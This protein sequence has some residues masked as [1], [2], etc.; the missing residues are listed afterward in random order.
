MITIMKK[1]KRTDS[2]GVNKVSRK[3]LSQNK[4]NST[5][6]F[7]NKPKKTVKAAFDKQNILIEEPE[8]K[9]AKVKVNFKKKISEKKNKRSKSLIY[10]RKV[11]P[12]I[13][14]TTNSSRLI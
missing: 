5:N 4:N 14:T 11:I 2:T 8:S 12:R 1:L 3:A 13:D 7:K 6:N 9:Y 10:Q